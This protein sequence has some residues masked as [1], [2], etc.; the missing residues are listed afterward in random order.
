M[1]KTALNHCLI[2]PILIVVKIEQ[3]FPVYDMS[4]NTMICWEQNNFFPKQLQ[5]SVRQVLNKH[6]IWCNKHVNLLQIRMKFMRRFHGYKLHLSCLRRERL[7]NLT[8]NVYFKEEK[9]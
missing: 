5:V 7:I 1:L 3:L 9:K 8:S 4:K 6:K 2:F